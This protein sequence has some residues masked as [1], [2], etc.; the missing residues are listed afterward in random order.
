MER[1]LA[2]AAAYHRRQSS[3]AKKRWHP[4]DNVETI[5]LVS[6]GGSVEQNQQ[7]NRCRGNATLSKII[8]SPFG[9]DN[10]T[11]VDN[12]AQTSKVGLSVGPRK[13]GGTPPT[14]D[15]LSS[16]QR[17][18]QVT[19]RALL[20][21]LGE[22]GFAEAIDILSATPL[23]LERAAKAERRKPGSGVVVLLDG[24]RQHVKAL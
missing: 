21:H 14:T 5:L 17:A 23:L 12:L 10:L 20:L 13:T 22:S 1:D 7:L 2:T 19:L 18:E 3:I 9:T 6:P 8:K 15:R 16:H 11:D 4:V 24:L